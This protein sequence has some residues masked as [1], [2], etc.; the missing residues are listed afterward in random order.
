[1]LDHFGWTSEQFRDWLADSVTRL[2]LSD[3]R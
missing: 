3:E 1:M 2:L